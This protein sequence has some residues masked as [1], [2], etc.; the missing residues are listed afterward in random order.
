MEITRI[1]MESIVKEAW[2]I[3]WEKVEKD[4]RKYWK[5]PNI[6]IK[7]AIENNEILG[8]FCVEIQEKDLFLGQIHVSPIRQT[9]GI[10]SQLMKEIENIALEMGYNSILLNVQANNERAKNFFE[11]RGFFKIE[12]KEFDI[13]MRKD[14]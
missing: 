8:Y 9:Q 10:G 1:T 11:K 12:R 6:I 13:L 4:L 7:V 3:E 2:S 5:K 14:L